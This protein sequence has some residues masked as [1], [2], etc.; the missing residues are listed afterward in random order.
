MANLYDPPAKRTLPLSKGQDVNVTFEYVDS[1]GLP[2][3]FTG[4]SAS[5]VIDHT[6]PISVPATVS[7][8]NLTVR[9]ESTVLDPVVDGTTWRLVLSWAGSP[10]FEQVAVNGAVKR[11]DG[12]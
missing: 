2:T 11:Y 6:A 7:G 8:S 10:T 4:L 3:P 1:A 5:M 9:I 12:A